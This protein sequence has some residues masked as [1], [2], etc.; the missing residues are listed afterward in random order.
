MIL[1][2]AGSSQQGRSKRKGEGDDENAAPVK[3][4]TRKTADPKPAKP[5]KPAPARKAKV[6]KAQEKAQKSQAKP[7]N[8]KDESKPTAEKKP[9]KPRAKKP[10]GP[11]VDLPANPLRTDSL[12]TSLMEFAEKFPEALEDNETKLRKAILDETT[13]LQYTK[14]MPYWSR[15]GCGVKVLTYDGSWENYMSFSFNSS[16]APRRYKLAVA[17]RCAELAAT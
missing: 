14:L 8:G 17:V 16:S 2:S 1:A 12:V 3:S 11:G 9:R 6:P 13:S 4:R 5:A 7:K 15:S 10:S